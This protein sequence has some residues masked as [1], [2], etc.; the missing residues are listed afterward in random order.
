M[1]PPFFA[2]YFEA[3]MAKG[4]LLEYSLR[5]VH[6]GLCSAS[7]KLLIMIDWDLF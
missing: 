2:H 5:H 3:K 6:T 7:Y 4:R 1:R